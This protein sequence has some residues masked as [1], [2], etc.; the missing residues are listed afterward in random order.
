MSIS[1]LDGIVN[2]EKSAD[3][4]NYKKCKK[5]ADFNKVSQVERNQKERILR[6]RSPLFANGA[7]LAFFLKKI[8]SYSCFAREKKSDAHSTQTKFLMIPPTVM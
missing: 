7:H 6:T 5:N 2:I 3:Q 8:D 4:R 1:F